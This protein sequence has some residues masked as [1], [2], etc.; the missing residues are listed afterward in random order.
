MGGGVNWFRSEGSWFYVYGPLHDAPPTCHHGADG[1]NP[2]P[3]FPLPR[4]LGK[5]SPQGSP[6][7]GPSSPAAGDAANPVP[8]GPPGAGV[9]PLPHRHRRLQPRG[10][11]PP[12]P[13]GRPTGSDLLIP[14]HY[15]VMRPPRQYPPPLPPRGI[16]AAGGVGVEP[17]LR[18]RPP[19]PWGGCVC[20]SQIPFHLHVS[21]PPQY[22][23]R[24]RCFGRRR[25]WSAAAWNRAFLAA[26]GTPP[27]GGG[28]PAYTKQ[29]CEGRPASQVSTRGVRV[30][31]ALP[32]VTS[33]LS[34]PRGVRH[35]HQQAD[36]LRD[37]PG[38]FLRV[39]DPPSSGGCLWI[40]GGGGCCADSPPPPDGVYTIQN[41]NVMKRNRN[42]TRARGDAKQGIS[43]H[44]FCQK[45]LI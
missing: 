12:T 18:R 21:H 38:F 8:A 14:F 27:L 17:F 25:G 2:A 43:N 37:P 15:H 22:P 6:S 13:T 9:D 45:V 34:V 30:Q 3:P 29:L 36:R 10:A 7:I 35:R 19:R 4:L 28:R 5:S 16:A 40:W 39:G 42:V 31:G 26:E 11:P 32:S 33:P 24:T 41:C 20:G 1:L 23:L 44:C